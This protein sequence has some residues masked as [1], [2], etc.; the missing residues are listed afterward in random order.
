ME[1]DIP[2]ALEDMKNLQR[3]VGALFG[4]KIFYLEEH[5]SSF[6]PPLFFGEQNEQE[7]RDLY[8]QFQFLGM[9]V[10]MAIKESAGRFESIQLED[11]RRQ[12]NEVERRFHELGKMER[13]IKD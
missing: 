8:A 12:L 9:S 10:R 1:I 7:I 6:L 3:R 4:W 11:W 2:R 13:S 5:G